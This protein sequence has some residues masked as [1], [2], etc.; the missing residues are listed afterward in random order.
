MQEFKI[1]KETIDDIKFL[2]AKKSNQKL[3]NK[4]RNLHYADIAEIL[5]K[6]STEEGTY[7]IKLLD[8]EKTA[9]VQ[10]RK[11]QHIVV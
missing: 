11:V 9:D 10:V 3:H 1:N 6:I 8:S 7:L 2:V 4:L 5:S